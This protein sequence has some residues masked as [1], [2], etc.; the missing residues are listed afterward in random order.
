MEQNEKIKILIEQFK[1]GNKDSF[2]ELINLS[3]EPVYKIIYAIINS[4]EN[5][6]EVLDEVI[7][8]AYTNLDKLRHP[9]FFKTW[10][11]RIAINESRNYLKKNSKIIYMEDCDKE[12]SLPNNVEEKIDFETALNTLG[13]ET[14][15]VIIMKCYMNFTFDEIAISLDKPVGTIKTWYYKGLDKLKTQLD[16]I[17][18]EVTNHE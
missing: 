5:S 1:N 8:K 12:K 2:V 9:E 16:G 3:R 13:L 15:S 11:I 7:Y 6:I 4:Q 10:I 17:Q 18:G 14:K